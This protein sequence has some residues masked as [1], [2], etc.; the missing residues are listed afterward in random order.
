MQWTNLGNRNLKA[1]QDRGGALPGGA[2]AGGI[3]ATGTTP[4]APDPARVEV[5]E[6]PLVLRDPEDP[7]RGRAAGGGGGGG[8]LDGTTSSAPG[9]AAYLKES[10]TIFAATCSGQP[11]CLAAW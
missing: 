11:D 2:D 9:A 10:V 6:S 1:S 8:G 4:E 3:P 7:S 5:A